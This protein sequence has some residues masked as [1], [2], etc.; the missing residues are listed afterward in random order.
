MALPLTYKSGN[1]FINSFINKRHTYK[2]KDLKLVIGSIGFNGWFEF[3]G[4][5]WKLKDF[6]KRHEV[7]SVCW[8]AHCWLEDAEG[9]IYD[10]AFED[11]SEVARI[12]TR[13]PIRHHGL[14]EGQSKAWCEERG[15]TYV[16]ADA[17]TSKAI[18]ISIF[19]WLLEVEA[20]L[21]SGKATWFGRGEFGMLQT[22]LSMS[23]NP[24]DLLGLVRC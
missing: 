21:I 11:Y 22:P 14:I 3:G 9:N 8:D 10:F 12:Q 16:P 19:K 20:N 6:L 24:K 15:L 5:D 1:C 18:F 7:G 4:K 17:E 23:T 2:D 13:K